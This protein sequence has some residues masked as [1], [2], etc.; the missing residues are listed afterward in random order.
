MNPVAVAAHDSHDATDFRI[1]ILTP[2]GRDA[3]LAE[4]TL[5]RSGLRPH[6]CADLES[7]RRE[8]A[9]GAGAVLIV[10]EA[11][12]GK[13]AAKQD[14]LI[15]SEP[16]WSSMP[17]VMLLGRSAASRDFIAL[18]WL[19]RRPNVNFLERP[20]PKR[21]LVSTLRAAIEARRL[22]Y[23][24]RD[25]L[26][27]AES[28]GRKKDE[29][30]ATLA[31][32]LRNPLAPIRSAVYVLRRLNGDDAASREKA[33]SLISMVERQ[34]DH[35][36]RLVDD[37]LEVSRISTG[38]ITLQR[39]VVNL[40]DIIE[41]AVEI[42]EPLIK[43]EQHE[44]V[45][46]LGDERLAVNGDPVRLAQV[47]AN[48]IN[49]AA[50]YTPRGG[51][52]EISLRRERQTAVVSVRDNGMG[53]LPG[54]LPRVFELFSQ[55]YRARGRDQGGL[56]IGLALVR[57]LTE[58][59]EGR[60]EARSGGAG[61]GSEF[62]ISLPVVVTRG[63]RAKVESSVYTPST[64]RRVLVVDDD[65]DVADSFVVLLQS[66]GAETRVAY[67]GA[68]ALDGMAAF[69]PHLAFLDIGMPEMDGYEISRRIR[70]SPGGEDIVLVALSG[71]GSE[72]DR[73][74]TL[75]AGFDCHYVKPISFETLAKILASN[76]LDNLSPGR[77]CPEESGALP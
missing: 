4:Q 15:D 5:L 18:H 6:V 75:E 29:F 55:S 49:N 63:E 71:W 69:K 72:K 12:A 62:V 54:M 66:L 44:L 61:Q 36:V 3:A 28:A 11:L 9:I 23:I 17:I 57:S 38:K 68:E 27:T 10:E 65:K 21:T 56:G 46:S 24:I 45:V 47:F 42:S 31:H 35:L 34:V 16:P 26:E 77:I 48:L 64:S 22:Q 7:L 14:A 50:K 25:A 1:L 43:S 73:Q 13:D 2:Q 53:I 8:I 60:V 52:I 58:M 33:S 39:R 40:A 30:L 51:R 19:E 70:L 41:R 76:A 67:S 74:L 32:E 37:L 20:V 59:H